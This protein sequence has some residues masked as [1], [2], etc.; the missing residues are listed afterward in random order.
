MVLNSGRLL[1]N[2][3][4]D[5]ILMSEQKATES[6]ILGDKFLGDFE[7]LL[8]TI[9]A[10]FMALSN[11]P[12]TPAAGAAARLALDVVRPIKDSIESFKSKRVKTS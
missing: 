7:V 9:D 8:D 4:T 10:V 11:E 5:S 3:T 1:F 6:V 12:M 2:T